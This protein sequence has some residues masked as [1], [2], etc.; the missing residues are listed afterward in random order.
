MLILQK[1]HSNHSSHLTRKGLKT[2]KPLNRRATLLVWGILLTV[3]LL[4]VIAG[5]SNEEGAPEDPAS[6]D[7]TG[8]VDEDKS[9]EDEDEEGKGD[10]EKNKESD[11][12]ET[13][14][15]DLPEE[16]E[17]LPPN[18]VG[19]V[20][21]LMYHEIGEPE[22]EWVRTPDNF[23]K[24]LETLYE[25]GY[26]PVSMNDMIDGKIDIPKGTTPV[27]LTFDDGTEGQFRY[28]EEDGELV[29]DPDCAVGI[30]EDFHEEHPDFGL[31]ATFYIF[32]D[33]PF[34]QQEYVEKKLNYLVDRG[35]EIGNHAYSHENLSNLSPAGVE[36]ALGKF[37]KRTQDYVPGY[38]VRSLALPYGAKPDPEELAVRGSYEGTEYHHE[39]VLEVGWY[40][41]PSPFSKD[42]GT[43]LPRVRASEMKTDGT[44]MYYRIDGYRETPQ[45]RYISDGNPYTVTVPEDRKEEVT[46]NLP[47]HIEEVITK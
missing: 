10:D 37:V 18:E 34:R 11:E 28:I 3:T 33:N 27:V 43:F 9:P 7:D 22:A 23:R 47:E 12:I 21:I 44:G 5:C 26:R 17:S 35:F 29:I 45:R 4:F 1:N 14:D 16:I 20:M 41:G 38:E 39:A 19:E 32:Y 46:D 36:E 42:F 13:V 30:M 15:I 31:E 8:Y 2:F 25:E 40:P 24:D 6:V